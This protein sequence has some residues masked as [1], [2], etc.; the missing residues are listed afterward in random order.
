MLKRWS[1]QI[2]KANQDRPGQPACLAQYNTYEARALLC[3]LLRRVRQGEEIVIAHAGN[4]VALL[5]PYRREVP[6]RPGVIHAR[7]VIEPRDDARP[8]E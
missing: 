5:T 2:R 1:R 6:R 7:V 4:P 8:E 3:D